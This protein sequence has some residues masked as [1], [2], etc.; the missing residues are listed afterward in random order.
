M[1]SKFSQRSNNKR[2]LQYASFLPNKDAYFLELVRT[3]KTAVSGLPRRH[4]SLSY[5]SVKEPQSIGIRRKK[6]E[7]RT[8]SR[9]DNISAKENRFPPKN[10]DV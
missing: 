8:L 2:F 3:F 4:R 1:C 9:I 10:L 7:E 5:Y 6:G